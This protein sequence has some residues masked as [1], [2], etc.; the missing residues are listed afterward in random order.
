MKQIIKHKEMI[1]Y[2]FIRQYMLKK[3]RMPTV[4]MIAR[5]FKLTETRIYQLYKV[6][7]KKGYLIKPEPWRLSDM[8]DKKVT[9]VS[10]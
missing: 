4:S 8:V 6:L 9:F 1:I 5:H 2:D 10:Y 3:D 7:A